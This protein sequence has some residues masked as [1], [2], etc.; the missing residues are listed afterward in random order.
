MLKKIYDEM[1]PSSELKGVYE[2]LVP[3]P[4]D[5][6]AYVQTSTPDPDMN[7]PAAEVLFELYDEAELNPDEAEAVLGV[8]AGV[9]EPTEIA[10]IIEE[11]N[12]GMR[13]KPKTQG[14]EAEPEPEEETEDAPYR[15][16]IPPET[17]SHDPGD[18][19]NHK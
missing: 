4:P 10:H 5:P 3:K 14:Q 17:G 19:W 8:I 6:F 15:E 12:A 13:S 7:V 2:S 11:F 16:F 1:I 18:W 9:V